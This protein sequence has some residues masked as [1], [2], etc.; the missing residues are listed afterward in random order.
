MKKFIP[1]ILSAAAFAIMFSCV[2][3]NAVGSNDDGVSL[4]EFTESEIPPDS[5]MASFVLPSAPDFGSGVSVH[6][7]SI[8]KDDDGTYYTFG[9][10]FAVAS[11][12]NLVR[13]TQYAGDNQTHRLYGGTSSSNSP[14][15]T[16]LADAFAHVG[17]DRDG[18]PPGSTWAPDVVKLDGRYYMYYS[19]STWGS[20]RSYIGRVDANSVTGP[21]SNSAEVVKT[22]APG[23]SRAPNA[24]DPALFYDKEGKLWMSYGSFFEGIYIFE[25]ETSGQRIGLVKPGQGNYGKRI[26]AGGEGPEG[27]YIFYNPDTDYYYLMVT[28]GSLSTDYNMRV[29]RS[30]NPDGPYVDI[31]GRDVTNSNP[32]GAGSV[33]NKLAGNYRFEGAPR[34]YAA[35]GHNSVLIEN[36]RYFVIY[37]TRYQSGTN[38]VSGNHNQF[39]NQLFFNDE[40]WPVMAP[41]RCAGES[42]G[43]VD[44][45]DAVGEYDLLVHT[46]VGNDVTFAISSLYSFYSDGSIKAGP[47]TG[48]PTGI[49]ES[50]REIPHNV[51]PSSAAA[52]EWVRTGNYHFVVTIEGVSYNGVMV[53]QYNS[54]MGYAG[55]SFTGVS[56]QGVSMWANKRPVK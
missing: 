15:R 7:P 13:W 1:L 10:H 35:L 25:M 36:G 49:K 39:V 14:W 8:F 42:A 21:Y 12:A 17:N 46:S 40:G 19:L 11:S 23:A 16:V 20:N 54:D 43:R 32:T 2:R 24:I 51:M 28:H 29:T 5:A 55:L 31:R 26:H 34:G 44:P 45:E 6:D 50:P 22:P 27:P 37:H 47:F 52:G 53:P 30:R 48:G 4:T 3:D 33:G 9:S 38:G 18:S 41:N 56:P